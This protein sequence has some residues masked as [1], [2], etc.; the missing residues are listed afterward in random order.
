MTYAAPH[1]RKVGTRTYTVEARCE[2]Y[3]AT[4]TAM[5][6]GAVVEMLPSAFI[7]VVR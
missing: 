1:E 5:S 4:Q 6:A 7:L 2:L 3:G